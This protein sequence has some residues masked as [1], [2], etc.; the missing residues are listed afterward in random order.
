MLAG[1]E[2]S[3]TVVP[4]VDAAAAARQPVVMCSD[5]NV[6]TVQPVVAMM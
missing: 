6:V 3:A 2:V 4:V 1:A 5:L